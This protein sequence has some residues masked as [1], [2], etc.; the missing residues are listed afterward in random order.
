VVRIVQSAVLLAG[1]LILVASLGFAVFGS[2]KKLR[3]IRAIDKAYANFGV[4]TYTVPEVR[5]PFVVRETSHGVLDVKRNTGKFEISLKRAPFPPPP[6]A[7]MMWVLP[8]LYTEM[9]NG[10]NRSEHTFEPGTYILVLT[11]AHGGDSSTEVNLTLTYKEEAFPKL[12][13]V[14]IQML[15]VAVP[16]IVAGILS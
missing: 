3:T 14:G 5:I 6:E 13:D 10:I 1:V 7:N 12:Y 15:I 8:A 2:L 4:M 16:L 9:S 11:N